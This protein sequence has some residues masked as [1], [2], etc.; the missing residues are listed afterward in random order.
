MAVAA[1]R[2]RAL[3]PLDA[4]LWRRGIRH[5]AVRVLLR[6]ELLA[7]G[8]SLCAGSV[9]FPVSPWL[10]CFGAGLACMTWIFWSW[11]RFF[12]RAPLAGGTAPVLLGALARW[13]V[14]LALMAVG[15]AL[16]LKAGASPLA[17]AAGVGVGVALGL[18]SY[19]CAA[20]RCPPRG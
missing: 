9:L 11:A 18:V 17:L 20:R 10:L 8:A 4:W 12:A 5:G 7:S 1:P 6:N 2:G 16:A 3:Q 15:L 19:A 13:A 14:R